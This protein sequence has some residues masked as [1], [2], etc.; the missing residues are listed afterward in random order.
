MNRL[1]WILHAVISTTLM[2]IGVT[3]VLAANLP[4]WKP[5]VIAA[6]VGFIISLP[7][8][9]FIARKIQHLTS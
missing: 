8:S 4:G 7:A 5:I 3:G 1:M 6:A 2:G 9:Y